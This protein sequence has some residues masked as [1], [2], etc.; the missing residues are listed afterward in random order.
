MGHMN[1]QPGWYDAGVPGQE[2]WWDGVQWTAHERP[3]GAALQQQPM[4]PAVPM[5]P[6]AMGSAAMGSAAPMGWFPVPGAGDVRWW[7]GTMWTPYRLRDGKPRPDAFAI[8][9]GNLGIVFGIVFIVLGISQY[10]TY[11][12]SGQPVFAVTPILFFIAGVL[13][14]IGGLHAGGLKKLP[15]PSTVPVFDAVTRPLPGEVEGAGAG[16][17]PVSGQVG[18][19]W[20]GARWSPY[21]AQ[22]FGVRPTQYG[23]RAYRTSM[24]IGWVLVGLGVLAAVFG[25][26]FV[27]ALGWMAAAVVFPGLVLS[28]VGGAVTLTVYLRRYTMVLPPQAPPLR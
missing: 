23:P 16:W 24:I 18:R 9:P 25:F 2:R 7:D 1:A 19:W 10:S 6:A 12:V 13:W 28:L 5:V 14:L 11:T 4:V 21:I 20:T 15:A 8:E 22:K 3:V 26:A 17:F 27:T